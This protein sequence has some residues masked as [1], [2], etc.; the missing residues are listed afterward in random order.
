MVYHVID[1]A[2]D[3]VLT[4]EWPTAGSSASSNTDNSPTHS[5]CS[6]DESEESESPRSPEPEAP[7]PVE[8]EHNVE[9]VHNVEQQP[10][11]SEPPIR[12]FSTFRLSS[13]H[14][15]LAST[16]FEAA[17]KGG[18]QEGNGSNNGDLHISVRGFH[19]KALEIV[20]DAIHGQ[21]RWIPKTI[22]LETLLGVATIVHH[23]GVHEPLQLLAPIWIDHLSEHL[24][25][26]MESEKLVLQW[27]LIL[28]VFNDAGRFTQVTQVAMRYAIGELKNKASMPIP[29]QIL[30]AINQRRKEMI[31]KIFVNFHALKDDLI[32]NAK[33]CSIACSTL[34]LGVLVRTMSMLMLFNDTSED[35]FSFYYAADIIQTIE[36][37]KWP[38]FCEK[39]EERYARSREVHVCP[40][41]EPT[42]RS[43]CEALVDEIE[44]RM[45]GLDL[46]GFVSSAL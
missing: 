30:D 35:C 26:N 3:V 10:G 9:A 37:I 18:W 34:Q 16:V 27:I 29:P 19:P 45:T 5:T 22:S 1:P 2:G 21:Y 33:G 36:F 28:W 6:P 40:H 31:E 11:V 13:R 4:L 7:G 17:L 39:G 15:I 44:R 42:F 23:Y 8:A 32:D 43:E 14:L 41:N 38:Y 12:L 46:G 25:Q 20:L 24:P